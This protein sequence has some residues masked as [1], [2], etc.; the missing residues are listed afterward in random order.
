M[1]FFSLNQIIKFICI[2]ICTVFLAGGLF[3]SFILYGPPEIGSEKIELAHKYIPLIKKNYKKFETL[4]AEQ[5]QDFHRQVNLGLSSKE[6][7][8]D[9]NTGMVLTRWKHKLFLVMPYGFDESYTY[10]LTRDC[11]QFDRFR[12]TFLKQCD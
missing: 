4:D 10:D 11:W 8:N 2:G 12:L 7:I 5:L 9:A 1:K 6:I 3:I